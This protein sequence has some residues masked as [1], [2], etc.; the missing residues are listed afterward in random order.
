MVLKGFSSLHDS[1]IHPSNLW[2][3][4]PPRIH[5]GKG[6]L[7]HVRFKKSRLSNNYPGEYPTLSNDT[8]L[9]HIIHCFQ[10][11]PPRYKPSWCKKNP[12]KYLQCKRFANTCPSEQHEIPQSDHASV[13]LLPPPTTRLPPSLA[14]G[15]TSPA[16]DLSSITETTIPNTTILQK[17]QHCL[18]QKLRGCF[19]NTCIYTHPYHVCMRTYINAYMGHLLSRKLWNDF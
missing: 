19:F 12:I 11:R 17:K 2:H 4:S 6:L 16:G 10:P 14:Y 3:R 15:G 8:L 7:D 18:R 13:P 1:M 9:I 5:A